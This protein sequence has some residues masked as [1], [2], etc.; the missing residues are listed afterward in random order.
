LLAEAVSDAQREFFFNSSENKDRPF[1]GRQLTSEV[2]L[3]AVRWYLMFPI[4]YRNL[5]LMLMDRSVAVDHKA[6]VHN[7]AT[8]KLFDACGEGAILFVLDGV[9]HWHVPPRSPERYPTFRRSIVRSGIPSVTVC[10][11][12]LQEGQQ[13]L[14]N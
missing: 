14:P 3:W 10:V 9:A 1:K 7:V 5:E 2:I 12:K 4:S 11:I 13:M 8:A 6:A